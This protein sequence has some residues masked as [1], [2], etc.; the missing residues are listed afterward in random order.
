METF[1][2]APAG[3]FCEGKVASSSRIGA[4]RFTFAE[5]RTSILFPHLLLYFVC[6]VLLQQV[7]LGKRVHIIF[8]V[9]I[10]MEIKTHP[11]IFEYE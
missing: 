5:V 4:S 6:A 10:G 1:L 3:P 2:W 7:G 8:K 11:Y 9:P